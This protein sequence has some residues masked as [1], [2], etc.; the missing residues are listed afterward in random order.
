M[1]RDPT[2]KGG[3]NEPSLSEGT[4]K[5]EVSTSKTADFIASWA[6]LEDDDAEVVLVERGVVVQR[7]AVANSLKD[8]L[9]GNYVALENGFQAKLQVK[10][11]SFTAPR[12][13]LNTQSM[14]A[15]KRVLGTR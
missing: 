7:V 6:C 15:V 1:T 9:D 5:T 3:S 11:R 8:T 10:T 13:D 2:G 4:V 12:V 14:E